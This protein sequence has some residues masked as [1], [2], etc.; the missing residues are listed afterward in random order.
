MT[1]M[2]NEKRGSGMK[3]I[4]FCGASV[5]AM[6]IVATPVAA[7]RIDPVVVTPVA[8]AASA[9]PQTTPSAGSAE[10]APSTAPA[11][12]A[13]TDQA[14]ASGN[15]IVVTAQRREER[16]S[17]VPLAITALS[18]A[19]LNRDRVTDMARL[20]FST[21]GLIVGKQGSD[22]LPA[23]RG[24][25]TLLVSAA[26]D[27][28]IG[29]Y[30]DGVYQ[31]RVGQQSF[32]IFDV[33]RVEV[34][35]GP[36]GILFGRNTFGGN[37]AVV[38]KEPGKEFELGA[39]QQVGN[40]GLMQADGYISVPLGD[41]AGL[42]I[43]G[44][45]S[46]RNG[47][48]KS[49]TTPSVRGDDDN[50]NVVRGVFR[51]EPLAGLKILASAA[52]WDRNEQGG[53]AF[54]GR[55]QGTL[56]DLS[57]GLRSFTGT[58]V[59]VNPTVMDG[60]VIIAGRAVGVAVTAD[61][62]TTSWDYKPYERLKEYFET[63]QVSYDVGPVTLKSITG[64]NHFRVDR[65]AD[66]DQ[67]SVVFVNGQNG[68]TAGFAASGYQAQDTRDTA[69]SQEVQAATNGTGRLQAIIGGFYLNDHVLEYYRQVYT[70]PTATTRSTRSRINLVTK[71][72]AAFGQLTLAII[73]DK[74]RLTGGVRYT[75]DDKNFGITNQ[76]G[77]VG[78]DVF[79]T[80]TPSQAYGDP[81]F[82]KVTWRG[83]LDYT[84]APGHLFYA[85]VASGY[86]SGGF[87]N[88]ASNPAVIPVSYQPQTVTAYEIGNKN[89][90]AGGRINLDLS[91]YYNQYRNLQITV[92]DQTTN[93]SFT[94]SAGRARSYG[95]EGELK[96][97][98][99]TN[100]HLDLTATYLNAEFTQYIR[101]NPFNQAGNP[102]AALVNLAGNMVPLSPRLK[103]TVGVAYDV[104]TGWGKITPRVSW[105]YSSHYFVTD[106][107]T[108]LDRQKP[109]SLV[110]ASLRF[111]APGSR[112]YVEGFVENI[113]N[114]AVLYSGLTGSN[115]RVQ[116]N[117]GPPRFFGARGGV[118]F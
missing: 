99:V 72:Y 69:F 47:Y 113:G 24:V 42:R 54:A 21:P 38:S 106:F 58:P 97:V 105:L 102:A 27:P 52:Y 32:P 98:P 95:A 82:S 112:F 35:R 103:T 53:G 57:T 94:Q 43:S 12:S 83:A 17:T 25:R 55:I 34:Q 65:S 4:L 59:A 68:V 87:N 46:S 61:P 92:L 2:F 115:A 108:P 18:A 50:Q 5:A 117:V 79:D 30:I 26:S 90:F 77:P 66:L 44:Y 11:T 56:I 1:D 37:I 84:A 45:H 6:A 116:V 109:Y 86:E 101:P 16:L 14:D 81:T 48:L 10:Q 64:F 78:Q 23:I 74:L 33:A 3:K 41:D 114:T 71:S 62:F 73:P 9:A 8:A 70:A 104:D 19:D 60:S 107:N 49:V 111:T 13:A 20:E 22:F 39:N 75:H 76:T 88:F 51:A 63:L 31:S 36:Q 110:D 40:Y 85:S 29:F 7:E 67:T 118:K 28:V 93:L 89:R 96:L 91:I 15:D 100:L 80:Q